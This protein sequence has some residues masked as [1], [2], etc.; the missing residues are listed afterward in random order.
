[1]AINTYLSIICLNVNGLNIP[2]KRHKVGK[3]IQ[4]K[5]LYICCIQ[6]IHIRSKDMQRLKMRGMEKGIPSKWKEKRKPE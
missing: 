3:Q 4:N 5:D 6:E 1:M 2:I